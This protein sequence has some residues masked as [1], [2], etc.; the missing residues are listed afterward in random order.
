MAKLS[1]FTLGFDKTKEVW[2]LENDKTN[3]VVKSFQTKDAA[4]RGGVLKKAIGED[5]GSVKIKTMD[6]KYQEE[7]TFPRKADPKKS[8]G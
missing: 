7:R 4:T 2:S 5:G 3:Q 6:Q 1:K 8:K